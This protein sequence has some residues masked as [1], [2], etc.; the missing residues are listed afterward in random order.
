MQQSPA[1]SGEPYRSVAGAAMVAAVLTGCALGGSSGQPPTPSKM[2]IGDTQ[3]AYVAQGQG[4]PIVFVHGAGGDWRSWEPLRPLIAAHHRFVSYSRRYHHPNDPAGAGAPYTVAAQADDLIAFVEALRAGPVHVVGGSYGARVVLEA[5]V[6][7]PEL[8]RTVSASEAFITP[9]REPAAG[10]AAKALADDLARIGPA[11]LSGGPRA[12]TI[13]LV[14]A[15]TGDPQAWAGLAEPARQ[16][17]IDNEATWL[18]LAKAPPLPPTACAAL[19][20]LPMPVMVMEGERTV[21]GFRVTNDRL[22]ECLP[23]GSTRAVVPGA[24]HMWYAV[25]P[26]AAAAQILAFVNRTAP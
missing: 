10:A 6:K 26:D 11:L 15:V 20:T 16:R 5:A 19:G 25:N 12:A 21:A 9:P 18:P 7:R 2:D 24:P 1:G 8:F 14:N 22:M 3:L 23:R 13:Q 17:F 4:V